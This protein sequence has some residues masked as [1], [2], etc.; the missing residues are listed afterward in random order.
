MTTRTARFLAAAFAGLFFL[1]VTWPV[2]LPFNRARPRVL[3]LPLSMAWV[4]LWLVLSCV[5]LWLVDR[6]ERRDR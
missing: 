3:G 1:A 4:A 5:V 6:V 2:M